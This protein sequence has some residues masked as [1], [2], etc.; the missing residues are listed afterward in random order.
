MDAE[1]EKEADP[2]AVLSAIE[3][4]LQVDEKRTRNH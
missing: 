1:L 4:R 2:Q 3:Q